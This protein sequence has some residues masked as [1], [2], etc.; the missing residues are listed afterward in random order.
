MYI[1]VY[2]LCIF[3]YD[4]FYDHIKMYIYVYLHHKI[5]IFLLEA[6]IR[7]FLRGGGYIFYKIHFIKNK[8]KYYYYI[9]MFLI[10][11]IIVSIIFSVQPF[12]K[13]NIM[14]EFSID[15]YTLFGSLISLMIFLFGS[16]FKG[17]ELKDFKSKSW[18]SYGMLLTTSLLTLVYGFVLNM[19]LKEYNVGDVMPFIRC[20]EMI[21]ILV[22]SGFLNFNDITISKISGVLLVIAGIYV[23][24]KL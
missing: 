22:I 17:L 6:N 19:L 13:K 24:Q 11:V 18:S 5:Y 9:I 20:G 2:L 10:G 21:W 8:I 14:K 1:Y 7:F 4:L 12:L 23:N 16:I 15:E 3:L